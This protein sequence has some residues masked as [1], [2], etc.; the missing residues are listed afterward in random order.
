[1]KYVGALDQGTTSTRFILFDQ[2]GSPKASHQIEH[3][4]IF[5]QPGWVEHNPTEIWK[6]SV[7]VISQTLNKVRATAKE[8][9]GIG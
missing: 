1:M 3:Q 9:V 6:N 4:Q 8:V 5:P 7:E 2:T